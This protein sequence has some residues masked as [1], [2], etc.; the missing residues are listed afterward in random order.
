MS[1]IVAPAATHD[2]LREF[3]ARGKA[4]AKRLKRALEA[5]ERGESLRF[6]SFRFK[7]LRRR[8]HIVPLDNSAD[9]LVR[10]GTGPRSTNEVQVLALV[11]RKQTDHRQL[12]RLA[13]AALQQEPGDLL[14]HLE[15]EGLPAHPGLQLRRGDS[16]RQLEAHAS[17]YRKRAA[18]QREHARYDKLPAGWQVVPSS[19]RRGASEWREVDEQDRLMHAPRP[20]LVQGIAGSGKTTLLAKL[21]HRRTV[22]QPEHAT[23]TGQN[24]VLVVAY[25]AE[26]RDYIA[27]QLLVMFRA[28]RLPAQ[29]EVVAWRELCERLLEPLDEPPF[30]W[31]QAG[32]RQSLRQ[33][34]REQGL[35]TAFDLDELVEEIRAVLKG[36]PQANPR[37]PMLRLRDYEALEAGADRNAT[38]ALRKQFHTVA[39]AYQAA[40]GKHVDD[41]DAARI[42]FHQRQKLE[43]WDHVLVDE[44][45]DYTH[46]QLALLSAIAERPEGLTFVGDVH[47]VVYPSGFDWK[48]I[49]NALHSAFGK[50][51]SAPVRCLEDCHR[52]PRGVYRLGQAVLELRAVDLG[53]QVPKWGRQPRVLGGRPIRLRLPPAEVEPLLASMANAIGSLGVVHPPSSAAPTSIPS[54]LTGRIRFRRAYV[55]GTV[56]GLEFDIVVL[57]GFEG[58]YGRRLL[59]DQTGTPATRG[60]QYSE[61]F[62]SVMRTRVQLILIDVDT[63]HTGLWDQPL[64]TRRIDRVPRER[65]DEVIQE[66]T[67]SGPTGWRRAARK[68]EDQKDWEAAAECWE[69]GERLADAGKAL[70]RAATKAG[71]DE[72]RQLELLRDAAALYQRAGDPGGAAKT[73]RLA[74]RLREAA[75]AWEEAERYEDA[76]DVY[77]DIPRWADAGRAYALAG[78]PEHAGDAFRRARMPVEAAQSFATAGL[79]SEAAEMC[80][81]AAE[82]SHRAERAGPGSRPPHEPTTS[83]ATWFRSARDAWVAAGLW[84]SPAVELDGDGGEPVRGRYYTRLGQLYAANRRPEDAVRCWALAAQHHLIAEVLESQA[85]WQEAAEAWINHGDHARAAEAFDQAGATVEA[86][87]AWN[88]AGEQAL[89]AGDVSEAMRCFASARNVPGQIRTLEAS[90]RWDMAEQQWTAFGA[91]LRA[92]AAKARGLAAE[93]TNQKVRRRHLGA[94]ATA[95]QKGK[96][97]REAARIWRQLGRYRDQADCLERADAWP[98]AAEAWEI[99][100]NVTKPAQRAKRL[101][102]AAKAFQRA[103]A[104][105]RAA[106]HFE[107]IGDWSAAAKCHKSMGDLRRAG[108]A[109]LRAGDH[110]NLFDVV[111]HLTKQAEPWEIPEPTVHLVAAWLSKATGTSIEDLYWNVVWCEPEPEVVDLLGRVDDQEALEVTETDLDDTE[112]DEEDVL[113][114]ECDDD[115][116]IDFE[117][118]HVGFHPDDVAEFEEMLRQPSSGGS[119]RHLVRR[120]R[121]LLAQPPEPPLI[122]VIRAVPD[123]DWESFP[124]SYLQLGQLAEAAGAFRRAGHWLL[125]ADEPEAALHAYLSAGFHSVAAVIA[126]H[127]LTGVQQQAL[128]QSLDSMPDAGAR[129]HLLIG[130][131]EYPLAAPLLEEAGEWLVAGR[132]WALAGFE[133]HNRA[134]FQAAARAFT[135]AAQEP[136]RRYGGRYDMYI[137]AGVCAHRARDVALANASY[138]AA[139]V[140]PP[141][142]WND[143]TDDRRFKA[144][145]Y[146]DDL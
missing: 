136:T 81:Q 119:R 61:I 142:D 73:W 36:S 124:E 22:E 127:H 24:R 25:T 27:G 140:S 62:T 11:P 89:D 80:E 54:S 23:P 141:D 8:L 90:G 109:Y 13:R 65:L 133:T 9:L 93:A 15:L 108:E 42:L 71:D 132:A 29:L 33:Y 20:L 112:V 43:R 30:E 60:G 1:R 40:L 107:A 68:A 106:T 143:N 123:D 48:R 78:M 114:S 125:E 126:Q 121:S 97:H 85:K 95:L 64:L 2:D 105:D 55:P 45:Q 14:E 104:D 51:I 128:L 50:G 76:A 111:V 115:S 88:R 3:A 138:A 67:V 66:Q 70:R 129:G 7:G 118:D 56:K 37:S 92:E 135:Q 44:A 77:A 5:L 57:V 87:R 94:A 96:Q 102:R 32:L 113:D 28:D 41:M 84:P 59:R 26:L 75:R 131:E 103:G 69:R 130:L 46:I 86:E 12:A 21:A 144:A 101:E 10:F 18:L 58:H 79:H 17:D 120:T 117:E 116:E 98:E 99:A 38:P 19:V 83:A 134:Y 39:R 146:E 31:A 82:R 53:I 100:A 34:R 145:C 35:S 63:A 74:G 16:L 139:G 72:P 52:N 137:W 110:Q 122:E 6:T 47:Q 4:P 91:T 49:G